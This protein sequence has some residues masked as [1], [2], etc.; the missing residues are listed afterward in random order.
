MVREPATCCFCGEPANL[1]RG[2]VVRPLASRR[3]AHAS[4]WA[5]HPEVARVAE[6]RAARAA[7]FRARRQPEVR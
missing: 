3:W 4:C 5:A 7:L 6:R 1:T 2:A